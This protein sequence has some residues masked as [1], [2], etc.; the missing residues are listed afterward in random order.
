MKKSSKLGRVIG[1][2]DGIPVSGDR[3]GSALES[4]AGIPEVVGRTVGAR[5]L[6]TSLVLVAAML[7]IGACQSPRGSPANSVMVAVNESDSLMVVR[8]LVGQEV[9]PGFE[10]PPQSQRTLPSP[11]SGVVRAAAIFGAACQLTTVAHFQGSGAASFDAGGTLL[12]AEDGSA[13]FSTEEV[14]PGPLASRTSECATVALPPDAFD[15]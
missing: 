9:L 10:I 4:S 1:S 14:A 6:G 12:L 8:Y 15:E 3:D 13:G 11:D 7:S 5:V 2:E